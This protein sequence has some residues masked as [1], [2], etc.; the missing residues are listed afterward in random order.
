MSNISENDRIDDVAPGDI[1]SADRDGGPQPCKVVHKEAVDDG[2]FLV[3]FEVPG[4]DTFQV[5][6]PAGSRVT[7]ALEAKWESGQSP[8]PHQ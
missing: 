6:Y 4:E 2:A 5:R 3:T 7:R 8:T 1:V